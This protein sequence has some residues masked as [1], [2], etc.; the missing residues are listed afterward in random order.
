MIRYRR[1]FDAKVW[2]KLV[3]DTNEGL[4]ASGRVQFLF[5]MR[6]LL[7][8]PY[9]PANQKLIQFWNNREGLQNKMKHQ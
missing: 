6:R 7:T 4:T 3:T 2:A 5:Y 8:K 9:S 1:R